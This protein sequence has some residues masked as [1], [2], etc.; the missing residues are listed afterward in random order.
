MYVHICVTIAVCMYICVV[1][2]YS[3]GKDQPGK[4]AN[5]ARGQL[6]E[7]GKNHYSLSSFAPENL[8][9]RDGF[10]CPVPRQSAHLHTQAESGA[11]SRDSSKVQ[12]RHPFIIGTHI[13]Y[14]ECRST[15]MYIL[16]TMISAALPSCSNTS[17]NECPGIK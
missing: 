1:I 6:A 4:V 14:Y 11:Y 2:T 15:Y 3:K 12:R 5:P 9:L 17:T 16:C 8:V 7:Q 10:R 13:M